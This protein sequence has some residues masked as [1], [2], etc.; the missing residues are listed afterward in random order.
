MDY[1]I[2]DSPGSMSDPTLESPISSVHDSVPSPVISDLLSSVPEQVFTIKDV[3][4]AWAYSNEKTKVFHELF[5]SYLNA[6]LS[7]LLFLLVDLFFLFV[8]K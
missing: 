7:F 6:G 1:I 5:L 4:P 2:D 8:F 3:S